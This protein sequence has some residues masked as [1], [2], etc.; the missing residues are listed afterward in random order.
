MIIIITIAVVVVFN[1][2]LLTIL[3]A[4]SAAYGSTYKPSL[5]LTW[6]KE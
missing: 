3:V 6:F 5:K 1:N 2:Y 4:F